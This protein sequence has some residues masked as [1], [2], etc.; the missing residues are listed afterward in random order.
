MLDIRTAGNIY[1]LPGFAGIHLL[2]QLID[3]VLFLYLIQNFFEPRKAVYRSRGRLAGVSILFT[4]VLHF[5]DK[6]TQNSFILML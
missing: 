5:T 1:Q 2:G 6:I 4:V 3:A